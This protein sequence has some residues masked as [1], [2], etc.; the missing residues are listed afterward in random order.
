[1]SAERSEEPEAK[2]ADMQVSD[3]RLNELVTLA[4][5]REAIK[6]YEAA[7]DLYSQATELQAK[8]KGEMD[9]SNADLLYVYG[10][11]LYHVAVSKSD[12]LGSK[13]PTNASGEMKEDDSKLNTPF[14]ELPA[15][16]Q[17]KRA[18]GNSGQSPDIPKPD[19]SRPFFQ[20]TGDE[21]FDDSDEDPSETEEQE[22]ED[23]DDFENAFETLDLARVLYTRRLEEMKS[24]EGEAE[25]DELSVSMRKVK[26]RL[27]DTYDFQAEILLEGENF[28]DAVADLK[29]SLKLKQELY[30]IEDS[31]IAECHYKLSLALEFSSVKKPENEE[32]KLRESDATEVDMQ[33]RKEAEKHMEL[34]IQSCKLKISAEEQKL[35]STGTDA[36]ADN[37]VSRRRVDEIKDIVTDMEQRVCILYL[38]DIQ[39][40][41]HALTILQL[42]ELRRPPVPSSDLSGL[43]GGQSRAAANDIIGSVLGDVVKNA[44]DLTSTVRRKK[45]STTATDSDS[46]AGPMNSKK[47]PHEESPDNG[48][49]GGAAKKERL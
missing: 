9:V 4:S 19:Q 39:L 5:A 27:A 24:A 31:A 30:P 12:V 23:E 49:Q 35:S 18:S 45:Q 41:V 10:R 46:A 29:A 38:F 8:L 17:A 7:A 1:M 40:I 47:R 42:L 21:N 37:L 14:P 2:G 43:M 48:Y 33:L 11:C 13:M 26:E 15:K 28:V 25:G 32:S 36:N 6:D 20:F 16:P 44:N 22:A 34:A 3:K